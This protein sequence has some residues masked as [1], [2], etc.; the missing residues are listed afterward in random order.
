[1]FGRE[2]EIL[3]VAHDKVA[4]CMQ[5]HGIAVFYTLIDAL[6]QVHSICV[7]NVQLQVKKKNAFFSIVF[8]IQQREMTLIEY[9]TLER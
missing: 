9:K 4:S 6:Q 2:R 5:Q 3:K 8:A 1:M 7:E